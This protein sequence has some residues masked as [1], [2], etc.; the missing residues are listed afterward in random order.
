VESL[1]IVG[2]YYPRVGLVALKRVAGG[3]QQF[4]R[5][6]T[7]ALSAIAVLHPQ[8]V[9]MF[10]EEVNRPTLRLVA[11]ANADVSAVSRI[12]DRIGLFNNAVN[13]M[14]YPFLREKLVLP[15]LYRLSRSSSIRGY[16]TQHSRS[17]EHFR[18]YV[19]RPMD[20]M[21]NEDL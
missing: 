3:G 21:L 17:F 16:M 5:G 6:L 7:R 4:D 11:H 19:H 12:F 13:A 15:A 1:G 2:F 10:C 14:A 20:P 18:D 8:A 9:D